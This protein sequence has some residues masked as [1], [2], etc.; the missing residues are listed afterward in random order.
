[1]SIE[2]QVFKKFNHTPGLAIR[3]A[4]RINDFRK[5]IIRNKMYKKSIYKSHKVEKNKEHISKLQ[6]TMNDFEY[7]EVIEPLSI[8]F[9]NMYMKLKS[10]GKNSIRS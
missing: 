1:M 2:D 5:K 7:D 6:A 4:L 8:S 10:N 9:K 3:T